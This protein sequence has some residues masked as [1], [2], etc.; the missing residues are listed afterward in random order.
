MPTS[1]FVVADAIGVRGAS[2]TAPLKPAVCARAAAAD[3][4]SRRTG[5]VNTLLRTEGGWEGHNYDVA[6]FLA[7]LAGHAL[8][9]IR[10]VVL[11]A[12]G[13]ARTAVVRLQSRGAHVA[14]AARRMEQA[15]VLAHELGAEVAPWPPAP[16]WDLLVNTTPVGT[17]PQTDRAPL[18]RASVQGRAV[19]DLIYN[20]EET[21]LLPWARA[22][23]AKTIGGLEMLVGQAR[24]QFEWWTGVEA[25][26]DIMAAAARDF[27]RRAREQV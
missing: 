14:I 7:P 11:G 12:G 17:W 26:T 3:D 24:H 18:E 15:T 16:G 22:A 19:Y 10:A 27:V 2:V 5:S 9:G 1:C 8:E 23:G 13:S 21:T 4:L 6:G 20:P 25:P